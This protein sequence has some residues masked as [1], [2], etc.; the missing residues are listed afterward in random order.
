MCWR[1]FGSG[2]MYKDF[3]K[4]IL[5]KVSSKKLPVGEAFV[6]LR[7]LPYR[8]LGFAK[9]DSHRAARRGFP[10]VVYCEKKSVRHIKRIV[11]ALIGK[12]APILLTRATP[13]C[14]AALK[15][16]YPGLMYNEAARA[17]YL[18]ERRRPSKKGYVLIVTAG[19]SDIPVAE[20]ARVTLELMG[21]RV[22]TVYDAGVAGIHRLL[23]K[24]KVLRGADVIIVAAGMEK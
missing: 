9:L 8:D 15:K 7:D 14:Y 24:K 12:E 19:T 13:E 1:C 11:K 16:D 21:R 3:I 22:R 6:M 18:N 17:V 5:K 23:D 4:D 10:E 20:G 2:R